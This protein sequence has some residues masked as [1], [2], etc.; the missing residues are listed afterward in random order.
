VTVRFD[1]VEAREVS[2]IY[3]RHRALH[4]VSLA[5]SAKKVTALLGPNGSGKTTLL[6]LFSTLSRPTSGTIHFGDLP[7]DRAKDARGAIGLLS[8]QALTYADLSGL[9]NL[10]FF[11]R[12]YGMGNAAA[13][14]EAKGLLSAFG[15]EEAMH[16]PQKTYSR[17]MLQR[18]GL[19]R[20]LIGKPSLVLLDEPFTGL[21][22]RS[23]EN[24]IARIHALRDAGAIVLLI[25]HDMSTTAELADASA[26][27]VRGK[28]AAFIDEKLAADALRDRYADVAE[29][30]A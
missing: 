17:G 6:N 9:E 12:L 7:P 14:H 1:R 16:R 25:S 4:K 24:L 21:D 26:I 28:L 29:A 20:A 19:A 5:L 3:G 27:L 11:A 23:T 13:E 30:R 8:H 10:V 18:L 15:L 2:K 22:R